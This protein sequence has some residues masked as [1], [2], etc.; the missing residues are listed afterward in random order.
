V[1]PSSISA[2]ALSLR[3]VIPAYFAGGLAGGTIVGLVKPQ[4][5]SSAYPATGRFCLWDW[6]V[7]G[8]DKFE[9]FVPS[10][11]LLLVSVSREWTLA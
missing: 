7:T 1:R 11:I 10:T 5:R 2:E 8:E 3:Y 6:H 4:T 9:L